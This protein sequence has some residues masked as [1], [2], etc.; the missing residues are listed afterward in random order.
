MYFIFNERLTLY[1]LI[2][3]FVCL[4]PLVNISYD[5]N[6]SR[7]SNYQRYSWKSLAYS[8]LYNYDLSMRLIILFKKKRISIEDEVYLR[9][10]TMFIPKYEQFLWFLSWNARYSLLGSN[11]WLKMLYLRGFCAAA[12]PDDI[13]IAR[14]IPS[15]FR[16]EKRKHS[17]F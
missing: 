1:A 13:K 5:V 4:F 11:T 10:Q 14:G 3:L 16:M 17:P 6:K 2:S 12:S 9:V 15:E 8:F 7:N